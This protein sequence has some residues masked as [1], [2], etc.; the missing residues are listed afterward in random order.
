MV[1]LLEK[2]LIRVGN[3]EYARENGSFGLTTM[4]DQHA[5]VKGTCVHFEFRGKSGIAHAIDLRDA[6]LAQIV[7]ACRDLPGYELFQYVETTGPAARSTPPTSTRTCARSAA[8]TSPRRISGP[9]PAPCWRRRRWP[10]CQR[11]LCRRSEAQHRRGDR[12]G[13]EAAG[14][15]EGGLPEVLHPSGDPR[16][17]HGGVTIEDADAIG[18][19][20]DMP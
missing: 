14:Q 8:R 20:R 1:Q 15:H 9:G 5:V 7:K 4:R 19:E 18:A 12:T 16:R 11:P 17:L 10:S 2:T 3:E 6:R 13:R